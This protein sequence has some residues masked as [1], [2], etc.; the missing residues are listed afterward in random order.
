MTHLPLGSFIRYLPKSKLNELPM[1]LDMYNKKWLICEHTRPQG[2]QVGCTWFLLSF[3]LH[4]N[5]V[6]LKERVAPGHLG[7][8]LP[9]QG[10]ESEFTRLTSQ[11]QGCPNL[12]LG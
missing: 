7:S 4:N 5:P 2:I 6:G 8:I 9:E 10:F 1:F 11:T 12:G 3:Y